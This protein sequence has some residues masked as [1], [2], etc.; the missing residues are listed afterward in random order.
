MK[1]PGG[2]WV[3]QYFISGHFNALRDV[4][5]S[6]I[7]KKKEKSNTVFCVYLFEII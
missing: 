4:Y 3:I 2:N 1:T 6:V 5:F 7:K